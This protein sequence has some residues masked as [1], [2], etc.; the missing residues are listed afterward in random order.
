MT[1]DDHH[2]PRRSEDLITGLRLSHH[3]LLLVLSGPSGV[4]KDTVLEAMRQSHPDFFFTVTMTTRPQRPGEI[5]HI[6]YIFHTHEQFDATLAAGEFIEHAVVY[7]NR[8]GVPKEQVRR[9]L[10]RG[11]D[12]IIKIDIQGA[13]TLKRVAPEAVFIFLAPPSMEELTRRLRGRKTEDTSELFTRIHT[14]EREMEALPEFDYVVI[15][16]NDQVDRAVR[17]IDAIITAERHRVRQ[18][19]VVL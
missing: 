2:D 13:R 10:S 12:A 3:P 16:E 18:R 8:Y 1:T 9:A 19:T 11:Q 17:V 15:N 6:H 14:A 5:D 4:G 7:G